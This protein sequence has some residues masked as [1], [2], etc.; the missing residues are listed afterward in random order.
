VD[1]TAVTTAEVGEVDAAAEEAAALELPTLPEPE[2]EAAAEP[3]PDAAAEPDAEAAAEA[4]T[5]DDTAE[6]D[7]AS[8]ELAR[9]S[10]ETAGGRGGWAVSF[11]ESV[12]C[13]HGDTGPGGDGERIEPS[14]LRREHVRRVPRGEE[15]LLL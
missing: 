7:W 6:L 10:W 12:G 9:M 14:E 13:G 2:A 1:A 11:C 5:A 3:E 8:A 15:R 4:E